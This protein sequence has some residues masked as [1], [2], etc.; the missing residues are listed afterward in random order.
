MG[1]YLPFRVI[2]MIDMVAVYY[3]SI[4]D[5]DIHDLNDNCQWQRKILVLINKLSLQLEVPSAPVLCIVKD[6]NVPGFHLSF[7]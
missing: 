7:L 4:I 3:Q 5:D 6:I 1:S 2:D